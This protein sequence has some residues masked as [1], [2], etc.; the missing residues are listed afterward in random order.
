MNDPLDIQPSIGEGLSTVLPLRVLVTAQAFGFGPAAAM[1]Q[2][3]EHLRLRVHHLAFA[4][5]GHACDIHTQL[6]YDAVHRLPLNHDDED[7][8]RLCSHYD[9]V[10]IAC[11][12]S[13]AEA[14]KAVGVPFAVYDPIPWFW[15]PG[16]S[17]FSSAD[18]LMCQDFFGVAERMRDA[19]AKNLVIVPPI[20]P[21][22]MPSAAQRS[23]QLLVNLGGVCN[24][25]HS[26]QDSVAYAQLALSIVAAAAEL[27]RAVHVSTSQSIVDEIQHD[28]PSA[29]TRSPRQVQELLGS[30]ELAAMTPGLGNIYEAA[31]LARRVFWL[32]PANSSQGQ[33]LV[34]IRQRGLAPFA[35]DWHELLPARAPIDYFQHEPTGMREIADAT[36]E[37]AAD[38]A[39]VE[40]L[41]ALFLQA[42]RAPESPNPLAAL[43][44]QFGEG[45]ARSIADLFVQRVLT[46]LANPV[47]KRRPGRATP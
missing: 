30:S 29:Q 22:I 32:P 34:M 13:A 42:H 33:Q 26:Q 27:Y 40:R 43:R 6:P 31:A 25:L 10:L 19:E 18:L 4:G 15:P 1:A 11:D 2:V 35:A 37:A 5:A 8:R 9:A 41:R 46:P 44:E 20:M 17:P 7:L 28:F 21:P 23:R 45:G 36:R 38:P 39:A 47:G 12:V 16:P 14:A 3:F 24:P